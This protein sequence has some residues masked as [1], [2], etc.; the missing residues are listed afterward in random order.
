[1]SP[2]VHITSI[3]TSIV[4]ELRMKKIILIS[5]LFIAALCTS[6]LATNTRVIT[7]GN[8]NNVLLDDANIWLYPGRFFSYPNLAVG[9]FG[10]GAFNQLGIN[11]KFGEKKPWTLGTY[12]STGSA[13][14][15]YG[16]NY[17]SFGNM[18][19]FNLPPNHR[20]DLFYGRPMHNLNFGFHFNYIRSGRSQDDTLSNGRMNLSEQ[21]FGQFS[22]AFGLM[23]A[24]GNW[25][26][27]AELLLGS[28]TD[29]DSLGRYF[30][31]PDGYMDLT[32]RGRYFW[33]YKQNMSF[34]PHAALSFGSH[35]QKVNIG[36]N[37]S[38]N[39]FLFDIGS[40]MSYTP[41]SNV[42]AVLDFGITYDYRKSEYNPPSGRTNERTSS[43]FTFP[44][45]KLGLEAEVFDW[46]DIR[47]GATSYWTRTTSK[48]ETGILLSKEKEGQAN[49]GTY[50]GF[51]FHWNK[52]HVDTY[53]DP[54]LFLKGF[55][56][57]SGSTTDMNF[58]ISAQY[59][60]F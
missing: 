18:S 52:L 27:T 25:D 56:F 31:K 39:H 59:E 58:R 1:M 45:W 28:W 3:R 51:G 8:N 30:T 53:T 5:A 46:M 43:V 7:M 57:I 11:W 34:I 10:G 4:K 29:T 55:N 50:L 9:E 42:L 2:G 26:V 14:R 24:K 12:F 19:S 60:M 40:G 47:L 6:A 32:F 23:P 41:S 49:N 54:N 13:E 36:P 38:T 35:G 20:M 22:F 48:D 37:I 16:Y 17:R 15:P 21:S 44:Y 33:Q